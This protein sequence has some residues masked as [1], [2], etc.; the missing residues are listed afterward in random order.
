MVNETELGEINQYD[1]EGNTIHTAELSL[2]DL[3]QI[4]KT[5]QK[6]KPIIPYPSIERDLT[7]CCVMS[8]FCIQKWKMFLSRLLFRKFDHLN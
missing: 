7:L 5:K 2:S 1:L 3:I 4:P 8:I 6:Y